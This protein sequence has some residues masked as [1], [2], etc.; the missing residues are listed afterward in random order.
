MF[1]C[2]QSF[3]INLSICNLAAVNRVCGFGAIGLLLVL[4]STSY[5]AVISVFGSLE[6]SIIEYV[7][8][9]CSKIFFV[10]VETF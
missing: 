6:L 5:L 8:C 7:S 2:N 1:H 10:T 4:K 3:N 9:S